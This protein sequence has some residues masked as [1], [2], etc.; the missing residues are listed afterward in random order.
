[1]STTGTLN[2]DQLK[3]LWEKHATGAAATKGVST[4]AAAI[5]LAESGGRPQVN[6]IG[7]T[8]YWQIHPGGSQYLDG[9][10]NAAAAVAKYNAAVAAGKDGFTPWTTYTG[11]DTPNHEKTY[12]KYLPKGFSWGDVGKGVLGILS[13]GTAIVDGVLG[14]TPL[15]AAKDAASG[16]ASVGDFL[17]KLSD[18]HMWLR[19][20]LVVGGAVCILLGLIFFGLQF[21]SKVTDKL[22]PIPIPV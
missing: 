22:P 7:A 3:A 13:P 8:G 16:V 6:S 11:A 17:G 5:A 12:K 9:D 15:G 2:Y 10:A 4:V 19:I 1:M 20:G 18:P 21:S 14:A